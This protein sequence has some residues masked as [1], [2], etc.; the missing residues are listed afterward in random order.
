MIVRQ[1]NTGKRSFD[2]EMSAVGRQLGA[3]FGKQRIENIA[4]AYGTIKAVD[5]RVKA[6]DVVMDSGHVIRDISLDVIRNGNSGLIVFPAV[7]STVV[8]GFIENRPEL[9]LIISS[10]TTDKIFVTIGDNTEM[11]ITENGFTIM[12]GSSSLKKTLSDLCDAIGQLTVTTGTGPSGIP[13]NKL[14][15]DAIKEDLDNYLEA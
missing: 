10:T 7:G 1:K 8:V 2:A 15:F 9:P 4:L 5:E 12:R 6:V 11:Q 3:I 14:Q 13:I